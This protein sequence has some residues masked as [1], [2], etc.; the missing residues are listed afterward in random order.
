MPA[1]ARGAFYF[2]KSDV[3]KFFK[4]NVDHDRWADE[5]YAQIVKM[6]EN[7]VGYKSE[8]CK[9]GVAVAVSARPGGE[10]EHRIFFPKEALEG[11]SNSSTERI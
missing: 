9:C 4:C 7:G 10:W 3:S 2:G 1:H 11:N 8:I 6:N 5:I